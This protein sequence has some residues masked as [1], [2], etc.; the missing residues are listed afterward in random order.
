M[1][2]DGSNVRIYWDSVEAHSAARNGAPDTAV[3][4]RIG[5]NNNNGGA[6]NFFGGDVFKMLGIRAALSPAEI[7]KISSYWNSI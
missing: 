1:V 5:A 4:Y 3:P 2:E 7:A 6:A